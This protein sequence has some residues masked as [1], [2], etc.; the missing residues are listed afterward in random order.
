M[1]VDEINGAAR[2]VAHEVAQIA[3]AG[4][5]VGVGDRRSAEEGAARKG[6]HVL[7]ECGDGG[8]DG[9][10]RGAG[11][12]EVRLV[13]GHEGGDAGGE[14]AVGGGGPGGEEVGRVGE[15]DGEVLQGGVEGAVWVGGRAGLVEPVVG[16]GDEG[17][18]ARE[19]EGEGQV[20]LVVGEAA[21]AGVA[22]RGGGGGG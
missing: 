18:L 15:E 19:G 22:E 16:P 12:A 13:E 7:L 17:G 21:L 3:E 1:H 4:G 9:H 14:G 2:A 8:V 6:L 10:A 11:D 5:G 20:G